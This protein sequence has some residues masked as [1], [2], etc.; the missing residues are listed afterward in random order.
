M[1]QSNKITIPLA[2]ENLRKAFV[3]IANAL[4]FASSFVGLQRDCDFRDR[5]GVIR[6]IKQQGAP[7]IELCPREWAV[8]AGAQVDRYKRVHVRAFAHAWI[9]RN[10]HPQQEFLTSSKL[11]KILVTCL[12]KVSQY[13]SIV[14]EK[15]TR[16]KFNFN[17]I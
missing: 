16:L 3:I 11:C 14:Y 12:T 4:S 2:R 6:Y 1:T 5:R 15:R 7:N 17:V 9:H 8:S 13:K 10:A